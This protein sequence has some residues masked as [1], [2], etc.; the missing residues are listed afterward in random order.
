MKR[1]RSTELVLAGA[2][3]LIAHELG[4][5]TAGLLPVSMTDPGHGHLPTLMDLLIPLAMFFGALVVLRSVRGQV[6]EVDAR[7]LVSIQVALFT[8]LELGEHAAAGNALAAFTNP[9]VILGLVAQPIIAALIA[10]ALGRA[11]TVLREHRGELLLTRPA[12]GTIAP[13]PPTAGL[14][15]TAKYLL[16]RRRGPPN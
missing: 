10:G 2:G 1:V 13:I 15:E 11:A 8:A 6:G 14:A 7:R 12:L 5:G 9:G 3:A 4:Y 16:P